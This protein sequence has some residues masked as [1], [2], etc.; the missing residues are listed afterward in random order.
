MT[1][2]KDDFFERREFYLM[3]DIGRGCS[4]RMLSERW[5]LHGENIW[6]KVKPVLQGLF[7]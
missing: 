7:E 5:G 6:C 4:E 1:P 2:L 3:E